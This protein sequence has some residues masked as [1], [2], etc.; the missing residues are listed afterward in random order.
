MLF[1]NY[2]IVYS[3]QSFTTRMKFSISWNLS[4]FK[5]ENSA[6]SS[7]LQFSGFFI[8]SYFAQVFPSWS[9]F[10]SELT[11]FANWILLLVLNILNSN[12]FYD[13]FERIDLRLSSNF[14]SS[15]ISIFSIDD[16]IAFSLSSLYNPLFFLLNGDCISSCPS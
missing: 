16:L 4:L 7:S 3:T 14:A 5:A 8:S 10:E 2:S 15:L 13:N 1:L 9:N 6:Y 12:F 11:V